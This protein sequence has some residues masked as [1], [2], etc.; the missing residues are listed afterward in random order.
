VYVGVWFNGKSPSLD[1]VVPLRGER[2]H[3][4]RRSV[5]VSHLGNDW[6]QVV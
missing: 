6:L 2:R 5:A 4:H 1:H 3:G